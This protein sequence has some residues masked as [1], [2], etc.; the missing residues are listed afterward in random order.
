M[1]AYP[2]TGCTK[3]GLYFIED[4]RRAQADLHIIQPFFSYVLGFITAGRWR[5]RF[6]ALHSSPAGCQDPLVDRL[7]AG[8][9]G[10]SASPPIGLCP[11]RT[12]W[13]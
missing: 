8:Q 11:L 9:Q 3:L 4:K 2:F 6:P 12:S 13:K 5:L 1:H 10:H 7:I